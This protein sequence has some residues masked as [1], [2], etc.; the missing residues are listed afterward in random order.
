MG[1]GTPVAW[2]LFFFVVV[3]NAIKKNNKRIEINIK[4]K[5]LKAVSCYSFFQIFVTL[6]HC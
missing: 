6:E 4:S 1:Y 2:P 5:A 3:V